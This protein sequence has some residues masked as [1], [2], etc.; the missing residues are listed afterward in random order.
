MSPIDVCKNYPGMPL[1]NSKHTPIID[2]K[3]GILA[4][5]DFITMLTQY[6]KQDNFKNLTIKENTRVN[7]IEEDKEK[8]TVLT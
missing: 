7:K 2:L 4:A 8:G 3:A 1:I 6:L 5:D